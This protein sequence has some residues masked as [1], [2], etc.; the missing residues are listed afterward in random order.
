MAKKQPEQRVVVK[1]IIP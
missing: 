1:H